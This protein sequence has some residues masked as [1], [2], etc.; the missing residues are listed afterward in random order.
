MLKSYVAFD[1]ETTGLSV[2]NNCIIEIGALKVRDGVVVDRFMTFVRPE[3]PVSKKI[4]EITGI[5]PGM[6][7]DAP[8]PEEVIKKFVAF[9]Q[10]DVLIG[11]NLM[12]DF[13]FTA[14]CAKRFGLKFNHKGLDTLKIAR[15][16]CSDMPSKSLGNLCEHFGIV[17][18][19][20]HRAYH[21][22][23]ATAKLYQTLAHFYE[24]AHPEVFVP[25][26]LIYREK[27]VQPATTKQINYLNELL[28]YHKIE[29]NDDLKTMTRSEMSKKIDR[30]ISTYGLPG[31]IHKD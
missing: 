29:C 24:E 26:P 31:R 8:L 13:S 28:K 10:E 27:K 14:K 17:N 16:V 15:G 6:V 9:C 7:A 30:I 1:L 12:F 19:S 4:T 11:H 22:A 23:L 25:V 5:T 3:E 18:S 21:D 2:E 20:A